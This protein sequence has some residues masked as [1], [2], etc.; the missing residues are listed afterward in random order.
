VWKSLFAVFWVVAL[1][2]PQALFADTP[3]VADRLQSS[4]W[5]LDRALKFA[6]TIPAGEDRD[7]AHYKLTYALANKGDFNRALLTAEEVTEPQIRV[8]AFSRIAKLAQQAGDNLICEQA[9]EVAHETAV[10]AEIGQTNA[11]MVRLFFELNQHERA[12][13]FARS[14]PHQTQRLF[15]IGNVAE[16]YAKLGQV[17]VA[18][19]VVRSHL[20]PTWLDSRR[21]AVARACADGKHFDQAIEVAEKIQKDSSRDNAFDRIAEL[22]I[23]DGKLKLGRQIIDRIQDTKKRE[24]RLAQH[25]QAAVGSAEGPRSIAQAYQSATSREEKTSLGML[26]IAELV[27]E[28]KIDETEAL[29]ESLVK[30]IEAS[31]QQPQV[32]KFGTF[33]DGLQIALIQS[34]YLDTAMLFREAG[35]ESAAKARIVKVI[36]AAKKVNS[37]GLGTMML[38]KKLI[39]GLNALGETAAAEELLQHQDTAHS[40]ATASGD[41]AASLILSGKIKE[42]LEMAEESIGDRSMAYGTK[43]V[44]IALLNTKRY[45]ELANYMA[46]M[47]DN[48]HE[49]QAFREIAQQMVRTGDVRRLSELIDK[50]PSDAARTQA[51]LGAHDSL[52]RKPGKQ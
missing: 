33:D 21:V 51:C 19:E 13:P 10:P 32:S 34:H 40:K 18:M 30:T 14:L 41:I 23:R 20:P 24:L 50:L 42:G 8:Y 49:V 9:L 36:D 2:F 12:L 16:E 3:P 37:Q 39:Q 43:R 22:M 29:I 15:A 26:R 25:S 17:D 5:W 6:D 1:G 47:P 52:P 7:E 35:D 45:E 11:H 31:P 48:K 4:D 27:K 38:H 46:K 28:Q 44:A